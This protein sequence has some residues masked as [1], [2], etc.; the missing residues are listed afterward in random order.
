V[1]LEDVPG[2]GKTKLAKGVARSVDAQFRRVQFTP[3]LLPSDL[4]GIHFFN[5]QEGRFTFRA[6]PVFTTSCSRTRST[7]PLRA[8][9]PACWN[10]WRKSRSPST[11]RPHPGRAVFRHRH[12]E[13][14]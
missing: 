10:A 11:V 5:Q 6:G 4:T 13:P 1:L 9:S 3:D 7:A 8:P 12:P 14:D 2:T